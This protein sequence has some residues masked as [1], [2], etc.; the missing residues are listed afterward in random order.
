MQRCYWAS[1]DDALMRA[2]HDEEYG[3]EK[4]SD[5]EL[6]EKLCLECFQAGLSWRTVLHKRE[7]FREAFFGFVPERVARMEDTE[8]LMQNSAI[9]R[10]RRKIEAAIHNARLHTAQFADEN[11]FVRYVYGFTDG[12]ALCRDLKKRGYRFMGET[13]C[14]SFL[15]SVGAIEAHEPGCFLYKGN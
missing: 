4:D 6:F 11:S 8:A 7:A 10:N 13:I 2:Y 9:I 14:T 15:M 1:G 12:A 5:T 3:R